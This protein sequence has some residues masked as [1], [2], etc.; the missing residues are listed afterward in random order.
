MYQ[1]ETS[2]AAIPLIAA[3]LYRRSRLGSRRGLTWA[4]DVEWCSL[5]LSAVVVLPFAH[6][7]TE[8]LR[9][10]LRG[11]L[12]YDA[13]VDGG[14][15]AARGLRELYDWAHEV[16]PPNWRLVAIGAVVL[17]VFAAAYRRKLDVARTRRARIRRARALPGGTVGGRHDALL[18]P[19]PRPLR[20]RPLAVDR[21]APGLD[22]RHVPPR[23]SSSCFCQRRMPVTKCIAGPTKS[24]RKRRS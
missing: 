1:K 8:S 14:L 16:L 11:D 18:H 12:V 20:S 13:E 6:V 10:V 22:T 9:I 24:D 3:V 5:P 4:A 19:R 17:T 15:G 2:L 7:V 23:A 21:A